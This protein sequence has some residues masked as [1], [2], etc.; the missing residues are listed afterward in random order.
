[1][2]LLSW[3]SDK[4]CLPRA[5]KAAFWKVSVSCNLWFPCIR[6]L[7]VSQVFSYFSSV[8]SL[9]FFFW[10]CQ[11]FRN[12]RSGLFGGCRV[13]VSPVETSSR[14]LWR[15]LWFSISESYTKPA[16]K[17][18]TRRVGVCA[19]Y[20]LFF[21]LWVFPTSQTLSTPAHTRVTQTVSFLSY[22][23]SQS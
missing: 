20:E 15:R 6:I 12:P 2:S 17:A 23:R 13:L 7:L 21:W 5:T 22:E 9:L 10:L 3:H 19:I 1:M 8:V 11:V 4:S 18:C 16:N 14:H